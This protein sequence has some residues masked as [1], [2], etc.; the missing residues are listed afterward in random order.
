MVWTK[1]IHFS[2]SIK[3]TD[4]LETHNAEVAAILIRLEAQAKQIALKHCTNIHK[5]KAIEFKN[6]VERRCLMRRPK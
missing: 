2:I 5:N 4:R 1:Q 3:H 6:G